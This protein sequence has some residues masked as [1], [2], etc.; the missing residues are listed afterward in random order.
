M[1]LCSKRNSSNVLKEKDDFSDSAVQMAQLKLSDC[2][3][4]ELT[5]AGT[6]AAKGFGL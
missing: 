4:S 3:S 1:F 2:V 5:A 6:V